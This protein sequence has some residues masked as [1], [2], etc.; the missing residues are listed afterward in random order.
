MEY[1]HD[2]GYVHRDIKPENIAF[3]TEYE[4]SDEQPPEGVPL[5]SRVYMFGTLFKCTSEVFQSFFSPYLDFGVATKYMNPDNT[6]INKTK[7]EITA[8][9][10]IYMSRNA[11]N[12]FT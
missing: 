1:L 6:T 5:K 11:M 3:G 7:M 2:H 8:G 4:T 9:S 12:F 10:P